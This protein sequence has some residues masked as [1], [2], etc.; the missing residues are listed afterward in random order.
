M[1]VRTL[2]D[3]EG[4]DRVVEAE[5]WS[6]R[7][8]VLAGDGVGFSLHDT[9]M[10]AGTETT[11]WYK[12]HIEAVYCIEGQGTLVDLATGVEHPVAAGTMYLLDQHDRHVVR[13]RTDLRMVCVFNPPCTGTEVHDADGAYPAP[14][15]LEEET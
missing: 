5:T 9:I 3:L 4:T 1:I 14:G 2:H 11:M 8:F 12:H 6:S 13:A 7:R 10:R 15:P